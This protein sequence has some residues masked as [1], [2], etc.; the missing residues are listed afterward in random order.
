MLRYQKRDG[1]LPETFH[2][3]GNHVIA[4]DLYIPSIGFE[5]ELTHQ[6]RFRIQ[7]DAMMQM[8]MLDEEILHGV[9]IFLTS[10]LQGIGR[11]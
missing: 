7:R 8:R 11:G 10:A 5:Q 6:I 9:L 4:H 1:T 2:I 3:L